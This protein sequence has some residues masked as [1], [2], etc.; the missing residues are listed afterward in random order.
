[1]LLAI[2]LLAMYLLAGFFLGSFIFPENQIL[3]ISAIICLVLGVW[4]SPK[5]KHAICKWTGIGKVGLVISW[6]F[7]QIPYEPLLSAAL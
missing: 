3:R 6:Q 5:I 7:A 2:P 4:L 1:M